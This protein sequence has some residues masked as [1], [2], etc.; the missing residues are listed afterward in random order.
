MEKMQKRE[1]KAMRVY[2]VYR[3]CVNKLHPVQEITWNERDELDKAISYQWED[4]LNGGGEFGYLDA[5]KNLIDAID[6]DDD[7][8]ANKAYEDFAD[9]VTAAFEKDGGIDCGE[10]QLVKIA[11]D[12][13]PWEYRTN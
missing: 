5:V 3:R 11:D 2:K 4:A 1:K 13:D 12:A 7:S 10:Y 6:W 9:I 8:T